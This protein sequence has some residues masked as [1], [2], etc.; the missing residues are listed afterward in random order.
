MKKTLTLVAAIVLAMAMLMMAGCGAIGETSG[1]VGNDEPTFV[2][3]VAD[4]P[5]YTTWELDDFSISFPTEYIVNSAA[6]ADELDVSVDSSELAG[7][8]NVLQESS[9][10]MLITDI[11]DFDEDFVQQVCDE[12]VAEQSADLEEGMEITAK[13]G[14]IE[15]GTYGAKE[16]A[17]MNYTITVAYPEYD[18]SMDLD[19][20]QIM[21]LDGVDLYVVSFATYFDNGEGEA[22]D[23]VFGET[24]YPYIF[25]K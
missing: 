19:F 13:V 14:G 8:F 17:K 23:S 15:K 9:A 7:T 10:A 18:Y 6:D 22:V 11:D 20:C 2:N 25:C 3:P 24:V 5:N 4:D 21:V 16:G 1:D 12:V